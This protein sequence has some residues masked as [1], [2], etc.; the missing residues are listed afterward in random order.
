MQIPSFVDFARIYPV[1]PILSLRRTAFSHGR[2]A[3]FGFLFQLFLLAAGYS[4]ACADGPTD[5]LDAQVR[6]IPPLGIEI[7]LDV[8]SELELQIEAIHRSM[9]A[10]HS[11]GT[12]SSQGK[13]AASKIDAWDDIR[14]LTRA[15]QMTIDGNQFY[16]EA[17]I[18]QARKL[19]GLARERVTELTS[20]AASKSGYNPT[21]L[22]QSGRIIGGHH[23]RLDDTIQ[24]Y[25]IFVPPDYARDPKKARRLDIWLHGRDENVSEV[26]FLY[27]R[28]T[29]DGPYLPEDTFVLQP[30][31]RYS[32][33]FRFAGEVDVFE[34]LA[35]VQRRYAIDPNRISIRGFSMGGAGCW[36]LAVHHPDRFFAANPGAGFCETERFLT[37]FQSETLSPTPVQRRLWNLYDCPPVVRNLTNLPTIAYSG[38]MDRQKEAADIMTTAAI[39]AG[40]TI[41]Y[42]IHPESAHAIHADAKKEIESTMNKLAEQGRNLFPRNVSWSTFSLKNSGAYWVRLTGLDQHWTKATIEASFDDKL[43]TLNIKTNNVRCFEINA[44]FSIFDSKEN[45]KSHQV[46]VNIDGSRIGKYPVDQDGS[47]RVAF[48]RSQLQWTTS[49]LQSANVSQTLQKRPG[50]QGP[51]DDALLERFL[52]VR[53]TGKSKNAMIDAWVERELK[54]AVEHWR[55]Q[56]RGD[57]R[58][59]S[60]VE[61]TEAD[62]QES[63]VIC[64]GTPAS[65][66]LIGRLIGAMPIQWSDEK[67]SLGSQTFDATKTA[68]VLIYPNPLARDR[69]VVLNSGFTYREY[70]YLNNARQT[71]KLPDWA[72]IDATSPTTTRAAGS[73]IAEGFFNEQWLP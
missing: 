47:F 28:W 45:L 40:F 49:S 32:N 5:N 60:D 24:P 57:A 22:N 23:S 25:G 6:P 72:M 35:E 2:R 53:P 7:S 11:R 44:P 65:N 38:G 64:F 37:G 54:H 17:E 13:G 68:P 39:E 36:H 3:G 19:L 61:I 50:L 31:G 20:D 63:N 27:R 12:L 21:W 52:I 62:L 66:R 70:D 14:C 59:K 9:V 30:W 18:D 1:P 15:V 67:L 73:V 4:F 29:Q 10:A 48:E 42:V 34:A 58:I 46:T 43:L 41:P 26:S 69:Y 51:I 8:R 56:F 33:A 55:Y 16:K 71:P